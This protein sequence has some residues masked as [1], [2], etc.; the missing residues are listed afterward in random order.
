MI[1]TAFAIAAATLILTG[2]SGVS[3]AA[4]IAPLPAGVAHEAAAGD[5][6]EVWCGWRCHH[7]RWHR[8]H[9]CNPWHCW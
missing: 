3:W 7:W 1:R 8:W 4:P 6:T 5:L 2:V 9:H